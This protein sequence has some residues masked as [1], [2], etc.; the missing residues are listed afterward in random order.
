MRIA[1][2]ASSQIPS[3]KANSIQVMKVCQAL[4]QN[5]N[6]VH[7]YVPGSRQYSWDELKSMYGI[8]EEFPITWIRAAKGV[9]GLDFI[10]R[11]VFDG[12]K[13]KCEMIY[14]RVIW[15]AYIGLLMNIPIIYEVHDIPGGVIGSRLFRN[16]LR[17]RKKKLTV[18]ITRA[19][20]ESIEE[21]FRIGFTKK[22]SIVAPDGV[23][24]DRY[25][26]LPDASVCRKQLGFDEKITAVYTGGFY[27]G[28]G[29]DLLFRLAIS[30]PH[31][32]F[33]WIGGEKD[34]ITYWN[35]KIRESAVTNIILTGFVPNKDLPIYQGAADILLMPFGKKVSVSGGGNTA[36][37]C[38][39]MKMFEYMACG[40]AILS[41]ELPVLHEVLNESNAMFYEAEDFEDLKQ[42]FSMLLGDQVRRGAIARKAVDDVKAYEWKTRMNHIM[43]VFKG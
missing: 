43:K 30:F 5:G 39:P 3:M 4:K 36:E 1:Y 32:Q 41:S 21:R 37:I 25:T 31:I 26:G 23:D 33:I 40:R 42:K 28:R 35:H 16:Y 38:S 34:S 9:K 13:A 27:P 8:S 7:L 22:D 15:A 20:K 24:L 17:S 10:L 14:T 11:S 18:M 19:L 6:Y 29:V 2:I 12:K